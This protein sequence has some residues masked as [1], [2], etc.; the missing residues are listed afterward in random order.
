L[1]IFDFAVGQTNPDTFP[2]RAFAEA[3]QRAIE[4]E[5]Y[6]YNQYPGP[7]G[8][9]GLR[10]LMAARESE[11]EGV[12]VDP[13]CLALTNGSMQVVTLVGQALKVAEGDTV[14][15]EMF[16]YSGAI[17]AYEGIVLNLIGVGLD[18]EGMRIDLLVAAIEAQIKTGK[19]PRLIYNL[20]RYQ[21]PTGTCMSIARRGQLL[22][23]ARQ[24]DI[25]VIQDNCYGDVDFEGA[26][27]P[28]LFAIDNYV[29]HICIGSLSK[30][31]APGV[32]LGYL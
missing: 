30:I 15:T 12:F 24:F 1:T 21:N 10:R 28:S 20:S 5:H 19:K 16:S 27:E 14:I 22:E 7:K 29:K 31:F 32:R 11:R 25:V 4:R 3:G 17:S 13:E 23:V 2:V 9:P 6:A 26:V 18:E 8:H